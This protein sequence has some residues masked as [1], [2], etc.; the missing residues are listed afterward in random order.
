VGANGAG[1]STLLLQLNGI[2]QG[3]GLI[4]VNDLLVEKKSLKQIRA[5][6]GMVFQNP[7]DQLFSTTVFDDVTYGPIYQ[8]LDQLSVQKSRESQCHAL[9]I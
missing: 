6:V 7:D 8:G 5:W 2:F 4:K 3:S 9:F 1:K